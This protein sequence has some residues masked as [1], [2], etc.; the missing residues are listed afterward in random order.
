MSRHFQTTLIVAGIALATTMLAFAYY[1]WQTVDQSKVVGE[2]N[3]FEDYD[4]SKVRKIEITRLNA[5]N[6]LE[7]LV[8]RKKRDVWSL[9]AKNGY[10]ADNIRLIA[11]VTNCLN[12]M[13]IQDIVDENDEKE[14][15][16][17]AKGVLDPEESIGKT[18]G[19][20]AKVKLFDRNDKE[21]GSLIVGAQEGEKNDLQQGEKT[22]HFV[23]LPGQP[24]IYLVDFDKR[25]MATD[26]RSWINPDLM[27]LSEQG[28]QSPKRLT[29]ENYVINS[30]T[31]TDNIPNNETPN[32]KFTTSVILLDARNFSWG[33]EKLLVPQGK[34][35]VDLMKIGQPRLAPNSMAMILP[36][37]VQIPILDVVAKP[38]A[39]AE[40]FNQSSI[41]LKPGDLKDF[42]T[43]GFRVAEDGHVQGLRGRMILETSAGIRFYIVFGGVTAGRKSTSLNRYVIIYAEGN[44]G[45]FNKPKELTEAEKA[46]QAKVGDYK[47]ALQKYESQVLV[48]RNMT[49]DFNK[50]LAKWV[51]LVDDGVMQRYMPELDQAYLRSSLPE[52]NNNPKPSDDKKGEGNKDE[53]NKGAGKANGEPGKQGPSKAGPSKAGGSKKGGSEKVQDPKKSPA[54]KA[55]GNLKNEEKKAKKGADKSATGENKNK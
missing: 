12:D 44:L 5:E 29:I 38:T 27:R 53:G 35:L 10:T 24:D 40:K 7:Q 18:E 17:R 43:A 42:D 23:R 52:L 19:V 28:G 45:S 36:P 31:F 2:S 51:F 21:I 15:D 50:T 22:K 30:E 1:P 39:V 41:K 47:K 32:R 46:D 6:Q 48:N 55:K 34:E 20:G 13:L 33:T 4:T 3:L 37:L 14:N 8:L 9:P 26:F 54:T 25:I 16:P 11:Q 49:V